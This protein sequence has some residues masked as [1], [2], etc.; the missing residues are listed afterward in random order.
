MPRGSR[1]MKALQYAVQNKEKQVVIFH[2]YKGVCYHAVGFWK[3]DNTLS[4]KY[5]NWMQTFFEKNSS[6]KVTFCKVDA[7]TGDDFNE[8]ADGLAKKSVGISPDPIFKNMAIK[9]RL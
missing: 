6:I 4:E 2:D 7:H 1:A 8:L 9:H 5:Y 3:R